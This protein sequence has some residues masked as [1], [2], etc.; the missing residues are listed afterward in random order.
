MREVNDC[1]CDEDSLLFDRE[2]LALSIRLILDGDPDAA[3][4]LA[5][6]LDSFR[7]AIDGGLRGINAARRGLTLAVELAY[8]RTHAHDSAIKLYRLSL[9][10]ELKGE[11]EPLTLINAAIGRS[12]SGARART[13]QGRTR[14]RS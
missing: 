3:D 1:Q 4:V 9:E 12:T 13:S 11:D 8:L 10:G 2:N 14:V 5:R 7:H 6:L